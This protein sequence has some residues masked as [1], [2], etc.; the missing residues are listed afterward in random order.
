MIDVDFAD[1]SILYE[2]F[3][4][5]ESLHWCSLC[6]LQYIV[7][8]RPD[9]KVYIYVV[10]IDHSILCKNVQGQESFHWQLG[11]VKLL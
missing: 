5:Q 10:F 7:Q 11:Y 3:Q 6:W 9:R 2:D 8:G 4:R 1:S